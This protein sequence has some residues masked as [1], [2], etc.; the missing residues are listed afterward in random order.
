VL[1]PDLLGPEDV[2]TRGEDDAEHPERPQ[3]APAEQRDARDRRRSRD[4][5]R[6]EGGE[7]LSFGL[8]EV[9]A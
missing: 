7:D 3:H 6:G 2:T 8:A 1:C 4:E 5:G 9:A